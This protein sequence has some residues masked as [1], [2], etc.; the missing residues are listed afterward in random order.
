MD[1]PDEVILNIMM[2]ADYPTL[3][4]FCKI[5]KRSRDLCNDILFWRD[6]LFHDYG[7]TARDTNDSRHIY[8]SL[9]RKLSSPDEDFKLIDVYYDGQGTGDSRYIGQ[10]VITEYENEFGVIH[11]AISLIKGLG[12]ILVNS[13][14]IWFIDEG[15]GRSSR[16]FYDDYLT[17]T[18]GKPNEIIKYRLSSKVEF[19]ALESVLIEN[20]SKDYNVIKGNRIYTKCRPRRY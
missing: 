4:R 5:D 2:N 18:K 14:N 15:Y 16:V 9:Y 3:M 10:I 19:D 8:D 1:L 6:K 12:I 20:E 17:W 11:D 13:T 7:I